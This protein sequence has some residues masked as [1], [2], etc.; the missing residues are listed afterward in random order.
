MS[1][2]DLMLRDAMF[3]KPH[4]FILTLEN[5]KGFVVAFGNMI[6]VGLNREVTV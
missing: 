3:G 5:F 6:D 2:A 4:V 1:T